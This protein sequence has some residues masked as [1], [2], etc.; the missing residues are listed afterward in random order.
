MMIIRCDPAQL[1]PLYSDVVDGKMQPVG[2]IV[3]LFGNIAAPYAAVFLRKDSAVR[4][5]EK[6][7]TKGASQPKRDRPVHRK[8][9]T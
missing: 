9:A 5:G 3:D 8:R 2:R 1:P 4:P 6:L 7:Y